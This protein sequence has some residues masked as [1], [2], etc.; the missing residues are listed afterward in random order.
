MT[1]RTTAMVA[2]FAL[3]G[4]A[5]SATTLDFIDHIDLITGETGGDPLVFQSVHVPIETTAIGYT[6]SQ[7]T[8]ITSTVGH[9]YADN[10]QAGIGVCQ[11]LGAPV[12]NFGSNECASGAGDDNLQA[13]E[14]LGFSWGKSLLVNGI[15][16]SG[17]SHPNDNFSKGE[18]FA[19][20]LN[21]TDWLTGQLVAF[22]QTTD[23]GFFNFGAPLLVTAGSQLFLAYDNEQYYVAGMSVTAV[24]VP[25]AGLLLLGGLAGLGGLRMRKKAA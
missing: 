3:S 13:G 11:T 18:M 25:A 5:A 22:D 2:V 1:L 10:N 9:A 12:A 23:S 16:F 14:I 15:G 7:A 8:G 4:A 21:G 20:S 6:G 24:P 19:Y 17:E